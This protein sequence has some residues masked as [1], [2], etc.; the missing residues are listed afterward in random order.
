MLICAVAS[1]EVTWLHAREAH[2]RWRSTVAL[3]ILILAVTVPRADIRFP[4]LKVSLT[5]S[6]TVIVA[7]IDSVAA[8]SLCVVYTSLD[9]TLNDAPYAPRHCVAFDEE[10][11]TYMDD[12]DSIP[13][14]H[15]YDVHAELYTAG[16]DDVT[17]TNVVR[18]IRK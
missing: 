11:R 7:D 5:P 18:I 1:G 17:R 8:D 6:Q 13:S 4:Y 2:M 3:V 9:E 16:H 14:G 12:W 10:I 15:T